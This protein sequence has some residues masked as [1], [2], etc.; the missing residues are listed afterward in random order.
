VRGEREEL[1]RG[2]REEGE[3]GEREELGRG[4]RG[5]REEGERE[6]IYKYVY[7]VY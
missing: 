3:R 2:E 7:Y 5:E 6:V 4:E 1:G